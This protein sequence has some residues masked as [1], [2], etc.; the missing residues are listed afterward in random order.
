GSASYTRQTAVLTPAGG[1][2]L[3]EGFMAGGGVTLTALHRNLDNA[4]ENRIRVAIGNQAGASIQQQTLGRIESIMNELSDADLST[5]LQ[6]FFNAFSNLQ[7][8]PHENAARTIALTAGETL[9]AEIRR[10]RGE[11]LALRDELNRDLA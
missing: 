4:L 6:K 3:P 10:Q 7:N 11:V 2:R 1:I 8:Q 5:L 9:T